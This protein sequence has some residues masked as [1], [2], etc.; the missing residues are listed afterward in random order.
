MDV[1]NDYGEERLVT[2][3]MIE[4]RLHVIVYTERGN[5]IRVIS[6]RKANK[7]EQ[8]RYGNR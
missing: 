6:A 4:Q 8:K 1:R 3:G 2:M 7:M 5:N